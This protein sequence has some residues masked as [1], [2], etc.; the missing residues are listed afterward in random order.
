M[1]AKGVTAE[2]LERSKNQLI[3]DAVFAQDNQATMARWYGAGLTTGL[4]VEGISGWPDRVRKVT[5]EDVHAAAKRWLDLRR[6]VTGHLVP[7]KADIEAAPAAAKPK[8]SR[9]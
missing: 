2:E 9:S 3:A 4:T 6:S 5:A 1:I 7:S 8:E